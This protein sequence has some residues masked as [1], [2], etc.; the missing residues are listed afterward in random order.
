[1]RLATRCPYHHLLACNVKT[2]STLL[3]PM[4][5]RRQYTFCFLVSYLLSLVRAREPRA[6]CSTCRFYSLASCIMASDS[7]AWHAFSRSTLYSNL[8]STSIIHISGLY[9]FLVS[10]SF[11]PLTHIYICNAVVTEFRTIFLYHPQACLTIFLLLYYSNLSWLCHFASMC[12][13][14]FQ[15]YS[16]VLF[17]SPLCIWRGELEKIP[18]EDTPFSCGQ[19]ALDICPLC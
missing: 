17:F 13:N 2:A 14:M 15:W 18:P 7:F 11:V 16:F 6:F 3:V 1:M 8:F 10:I 4:T 9:V 5:E 19:R 12:F